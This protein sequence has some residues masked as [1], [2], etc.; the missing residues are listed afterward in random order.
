MADELG[1]SLLA[2]AG[3]TVIAGLGA[4]QIAALHNGLEGLAWPVG[5]RHKR[6]GYILAGLLLTLALIGNMLLI[7]GA[8]VSPP[9]F[10]AA[11]LVGGG[12]ALVIQIVG[13]ALRLSRNKRRKKPLLPKGKPIGLGPVQATLYQPV[14]RWPFPAVCLLPDPTAPGDNLETL[15]QGLMENGIAVLAL[16]W[17]SLDNP[18]RLTLQGLVAMGISHL[19]RWTGTDAQRVGLA[20]VGLGGDLALRCAA[21]D[22]GV[23]VALALEPVLS[24]HRP[25]LVGLGALRRLSWFEAHRR[26][27]AWRRSPLVKEL[28][29]LTAIRSISGRPLA[30]VTGL[31]GDSQAV[32]NLEILRAG[33]DCPLAAAA[34]AEKVARAVAWFKEQVA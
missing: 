16:D 14:N 24:G 7:E 4:L 6:P 32:D 18:D 3:L 5:L 13:A 19:T 29:A 12:L 9:L 25:G 28:D 21:A 23:T 11:F 8:V 33:E 22:V 17:Q 20:G 2:Q 10:A 31:T 1:R 30:I 26:A 15:A 27:R 34:Q